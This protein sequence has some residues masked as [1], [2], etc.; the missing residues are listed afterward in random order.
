MSAIQGLPI[1]SIDV[2]EK[3]VWVYF[4]Q[5]F[6]CAATISGQRLFEGGVYSKNYG[7]C[8]M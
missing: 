1:I 3:T 7:T 5:S 8:T 6:H 2:N 4:A